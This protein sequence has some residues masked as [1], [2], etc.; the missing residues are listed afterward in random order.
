V[1]IV[2]L[3][4]SLESE[5]RARYA[6]RPLH[7][8][9][10]AVFTVLHKPQAAPTVASRSSAMYNGKD[11]S[12]FWGSTLTSSRPV[13]WSEPDDDLHV[14]S[15]A[16]K[17]V[18]LDPGANVSDVH[19]VEVETTDIN[20]KP[21]KQPLV[22][23][24]G[25]SEL[26]VAVDISFNSKVTFRLTCGAGPVHLSGQHHVSVIHDAGE[27]FENCAPSPSSTDKTFPGVALS[28][29]SSS[30]QDNFAFR[31]SRS[32]SSSLLASATEFVIGSALDLRDPRA[33]V[34][35]PNGECVVS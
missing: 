35:N 3:F 9:L 17:I 2:G 21:V 18:T 20:N 32:M 23:M 10:D 29:S 33:G 5:V 8:D 26:N 31:R 19:V 12:F 24:D 4:Q 13:S 16:L 27:E 1:F 25:H 30:A 28:A 22:V 14:H 6:P 11:P 15:L 34:R 7:K